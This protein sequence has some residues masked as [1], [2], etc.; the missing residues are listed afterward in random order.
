MPDRERSTCYWVEICILEQAN[1]SPINSSKILFSH[2]DRLGL[3][4]SMSKILGVKM[5]L[6]YCKHHGLKNV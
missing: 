1:V 6:T 5:V 3:P 4:L 2:K